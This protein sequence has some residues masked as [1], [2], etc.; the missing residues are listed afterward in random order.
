MLE[1]LL[2]ERFSKLDFRQA[3]QEVRPFLPDPRELDLWSK[4]FFNGLAT[5]IG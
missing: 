2:Q 3:A 1:Q 4:E 5:R